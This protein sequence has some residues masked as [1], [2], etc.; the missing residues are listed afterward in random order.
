MRLF[1][2]STFIAL[3]LVAAPQVSLAA[4]RTLSQGDSGSDVTLLQQN[5][6]K[7]G[8]LGAGNAVGYFGNLTLAAVKKFQC[9][10]GVACAGQA[11][12]GNYGPA[13]QAAM[14]IA[15]APKQPATLSGSMTPAATGKFEYSG[16]VPDWR[17]A[18]GTLD[19]APHLSSFKSIMPFGY[20][21]SADGTIVD[22]AKINQGV[23]PAFIAQAKAQGVRV[24]PTILWGDGDAI[25]A[26][27]SDTTKRIALEDA[28]ANLVKQNG[29]DGIDID[30][31]AKHAETINY[32]ATFLKGLYARMGS[33][34]VYCTAEAR[35]PLEDRYSQGATIPADATEYA[36]DFAAMNKYCDRVELMAYDQGTVDVRLNSARNA[37][38]APVADPGWVEDIVRL[39]AQTISR[40]KLI[41]GI[42]TYG[43]EYKVTMTGS[44]YQ[45][46]RLWAFNP[47]YAT[48]LAAQLHITPSRTSA[49]ELG[50]TYIDG[51]SKPQTE[52]DILV[53]QTTPTSSI[54][55]NTAQNAFLSPAGAPMN[56]VT[57]ADAQSMQDKIALAK[58]LKVRG[59]AFFS[60][61]GAEDQG[62]WN[63]LK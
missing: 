12:Y 48:D 11:G 55:Q 32:F 44:G 20:E 58:T 10:K 49:N 60:L 25:H 24:V 17:A 7:L 31:E 5:L 15:L 29:F 4:A 57:W 28:I 38:Y 36:N 6:I 1:F 52:G 51:A 35:M 19:V 23:W 3:V 43:Y 42:P 50:F 18:S 22:H 40:N 30:F 62:I 14:Q 39:A 13:T 26:T 63:L 59:V 2:A 27:L 37:P 61:G 33:K 45:Y 21:V 46:D 16:W 34:W 47:N 54:A 9:A 56:F 8:Y 53:Q 41:V